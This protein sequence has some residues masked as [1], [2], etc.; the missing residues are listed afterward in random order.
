MGKMF[1]S[2]LAVA[3]LLA[4]C[5]ANDTPTNLLPDP[6]DAAIPPGPESPSDPNNLP[7]GSL[8][9]TG[10]PGNGK[11]DSGTPDG[12]GGIAL[13]AAA[14][15]AK[16]ACK[17]VSKSNYAL[18]DGAPAKVPV[19]ASGSVFYWQA[20]L[21]VDCDGQVTAVCNKTTDRAFQ[22]QTA[23][24]GSD[25]KYLDASVVPYIVVP[26]VSTRFNYVASGIRKRSAALVLYGDKIAFASVGD[27]GPDNILGEA[28]YAVAKQ[29]GMNPSPSSGGVDSGVTYIIF[30][31]AAN[32]VTKP[33]DPA[34]V[35]QKVR[36][37]AETWLRT[38]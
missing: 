5:S 13:T 11:P 28:S 27:V 6:V 7:D 4:A 38:P 24:T 2:A 17:V 31:G 23:V 33:E 34:F 14:I 25:G 29:L 8:P 36:A 15:R 9:N 37:I 21:D 35:A 30:P 12:G 26:G 19:C 18:D 20:D 3:G 16:L 32:D 1:V 22:A 10:V